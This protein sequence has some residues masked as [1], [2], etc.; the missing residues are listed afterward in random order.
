MHNYHYCPLKIKQAVVRIYPDYAAYTDYSGEQIVSQLLIPLKILALNLY[1]GTI[2][3]N[4]L[5]TVLR[6]SRL[7]SPLF[8]SIVRR[9]GILPFW[10][11]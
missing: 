7:E 3:S 4:S 10:R 9:Q 8:I 1:L 6:Y 11:L 5:T 2:C